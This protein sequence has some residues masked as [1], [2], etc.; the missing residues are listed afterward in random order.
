MRLRC[1]P[2]LVFV[3]LAAGLAPGAASAGAFLQ[4]PGA[5]QAILSAV[6]TQAGRDFDARGKGRRRT[7]Y[8]KFEVQAYGEYGLTEA[9]SLIVSPSLMH[10]RASGAPPS[11][12]SGLSESEI[13][14]R[15]RLWA[16]GPAIVSAQASLRSSGDVTG[17]GDARLAAPAGLRA[18]VRL[19]AGA[20]FELFGLPAFADAQIGLR[21]P[22]P[23]RAAEWHGDLTFG[24]RPLA[25]LMLLAQSFG[26]VA[27][28]AAWQ[29][30]KLQL[31]AV[32]DV[33]P[34]IAVQFGGFATLAG[35]SAPRERGAVTALW[36][37]F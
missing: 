21:T 5:G 22:A 30:H 12:Y 6:F 20:G 16:Y 11:T 17:R 13:G 37:R 25:A 34:N 28:R 26:T 24:L 4:L 3:A 23:Q 27:P 19:M 33:T 1:F 35:R 10:V 15:L 8:R 7:Q 32:Y 14:G 2:F 18:D 9:V 36:L 29:T 31:S